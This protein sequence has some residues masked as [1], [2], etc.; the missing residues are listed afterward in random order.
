MTIGN[1]ENQINRIRVHL[2]AYKFIYSK[3]IR[4]NQDHQ[5]TSTAATALATNDLEHWNLHADARSSYSLKWV[6]RRS[7]HSDFHAVGQGK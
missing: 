2:N 1:L 7:R 4:H 6:Y 3:C 5:A